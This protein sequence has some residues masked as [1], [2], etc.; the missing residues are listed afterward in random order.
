[1]SVHGI[2]SYDVEVIEWAREELEKYDFS[3]EDY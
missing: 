1:M 3:S 2:P